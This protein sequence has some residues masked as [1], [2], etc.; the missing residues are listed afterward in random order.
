MNIFE[1]VSVVM[2]IGMFDVILYVFVYDMWYLE[3]V[4]ECI[5]FSVDVECSE[6][7][8]VLLNFID[9]MLF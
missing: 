5:W 1:V 3:V 7:I 4:F 9:C 6:S 2:V 8:V